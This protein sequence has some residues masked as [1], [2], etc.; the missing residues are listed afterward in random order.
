MFFVV[1]CLQA[2]FEQVRGVDMQYPQ[3]SPQ[4][5]TAVFHSNATYLETKKSDWEGTIGFP[6][7]YQWTTCSETTEDLLKD[8]I[9]QSKELDVNSHWLVHKEQVCSCDVIG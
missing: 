1:L 7:D 6:A 3:G 8:E 4:R 2:Y 9:L 5:Q